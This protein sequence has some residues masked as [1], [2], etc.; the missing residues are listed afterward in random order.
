M[1][2]HACASRA[3]VVVERRGQEFVAIVEDDGT[4]FPTDD[5]E[6]KLLP[7]RPLGL[8]TMS[9]PLLSKACLDV[10]NKLVSRPRAWHH[11]VFTGPTS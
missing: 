10:E 8:S 5:L 11:G 1:G 7:S 3:S 9:E 2:K 6:S 4:D